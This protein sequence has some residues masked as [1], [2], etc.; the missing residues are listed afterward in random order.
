VHSAPVA[1]ITFVPC[2]PTERRALRFTSGLEER[3]R[4]ESSDYPSR[5]PTMHCPLAISVSR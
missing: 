1:V 3:T 5:A 2:H 4:K